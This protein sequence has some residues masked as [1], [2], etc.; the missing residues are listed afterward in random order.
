MNALWIVLVI[1]GGAEFYM[2]I[3]A[4]NKSAAEKY[5][6]RT[7]SKNKLFGGRSEA[8]LTDP[9]TVNLRDV[10]KEKQMEGGYIAK[11][12]KDG[13]L[14]FEKQEPPKKKGFSNPKLGEKFFE[15]DDT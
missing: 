4:R 11:E 9:I 8:G 15:L 12:G 10:L 7:K 2:R 13:F 3:K 5:I 1:W 6:D 14:E